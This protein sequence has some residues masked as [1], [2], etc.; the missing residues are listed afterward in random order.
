MKDSSQQSF[1][2]IAAANG[3][4][5]ALVSLIQMEKDIIENGNSKQAT[6]AN[7]SYSLINSIDINNSSA[8]SVAIRK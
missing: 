5:G 6:A 4:S 7:N 8:L 3:D 2:H 1:A